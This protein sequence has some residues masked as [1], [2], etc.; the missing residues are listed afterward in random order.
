VS[1]RTLRFEFG[2]YAKRRQRRFVAEALLLAGLVLVLSC[3]RFVVT[4]QMLEETRAKAV[5]EKAKA[6]NGMPTL[7]PEQM[8]AQRK[9]RVEVAQI[10][11]RLAIP[12]AELLNTFDQSVDADVALLSVEP[13][14]AQRSVRVQA[15]ARNAEAAGLFVKRLEQTKVLEHAHIVEHSYMVREGIR[16]IRIGV[17]A[18]W[19][20][21]VAHSPRPP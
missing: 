4:W 16:P 9:V 21:S 3:E 6:S 20:R 2:S 10:T 15:E 11:D 17:L 14:V 19:P 1:L 5:M 18:Y 13:D 7:T 8:E 12:W